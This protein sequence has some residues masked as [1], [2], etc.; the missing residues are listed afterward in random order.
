MKNRL[1]LIY[2]CGIFDSRTAFKELT[3]TNERKVTKYETELFIEDGGVAVINGIEHPIKKGSLLFAKPEDK[4]FSKLHFSSRYIH[5]HT[6]DAS[7][8]RLIDSIPKFIESDVSAQ[9]E[10]FFEEIY[11]YSLLYTDYGN[12]RSASLLLELICKLKDIKDDT[13][14]NETAV[15]KAIR[16]IEK[17]YK[18][19]ITV[20]QIAEHCNLSTSYFYKRFLA[21]TGETPADY[22]RRKRLTAAKQMLTTGDK[23]LNCVADECGFSSLSYFSYCFK[24]SEGI[25]PIK[26]RK[27]KE[28]RI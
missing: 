9:T 2:N 24:N 18:E 22:I 8:V 7:T 11:N 12:I 15:Y 10:Q 5:F 16:F 13:G 19:Q 23:P 21:F 3:V 14:N 4:R 27:S 20:P 1:P 28:Y 6:D 25:T 26:Y 17:H